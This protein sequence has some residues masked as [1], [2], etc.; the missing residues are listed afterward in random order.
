[1]TSR[2]LL[3]ILVRT[4]W[5][6]IASGPAHGQQPSGWAALLRVGEPRAAVGSAT[7]PRSPYIICPDSVGEVFPDSLWLVVPRFS[8]ADQIW[9]VVFQAT[10]PFPA[11]TPIHP[12]TRPDTLAVRVNKI[13]CLRFGPIAEVLLERDGFWMILQSGWTNAEY[14]LARARAADG[15]YTALT[16]RFP[17]LAVRSGS[18]WDSIDAVKRDSVRLA[19]E[20]AER[21]R[22]QEARE[23]AAAQARAGRERRQRL[24]GRYSPAT[25]EM[26]M[27]ERIA[28]GWTP[29]MVRESWGEPSRVSTTTTASGRTETWFYGYSSWVTFRNG[30]VALI[31]N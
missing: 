23:A 29:A 22:Q 16:R 1:M 30:R 13:S 20:N 18:Q 9:S 4:A 5:L 2:I 19:R 12:P 21:M 14:T 6:S 24:L 3:V 26:I 28:I 17:D 31:Q 27:A 25:V 10:N 7:F 11:V 8:P 15:T